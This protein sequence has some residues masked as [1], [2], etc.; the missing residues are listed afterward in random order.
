MDNVTQVES[1]IRSMILNGNIRKTIVQ[2]CLNLAIPVPVFYV[3]WIIT[4]R[5][6]SL[7]GAFRI[8]TVEKFFGRLRPQ[9]VQNFI[10]VQ[11]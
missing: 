5:F 2:D 6:G 1:Q 8:D 7:L 9:P 4:G 3:I 11:S 10:L